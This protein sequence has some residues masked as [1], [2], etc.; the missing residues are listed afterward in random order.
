L[1]DYSAEA[2]DR[3]LEVIP[4]AMRGLAAELRKSGQNLEPSHFRL[5]ACLH[6]EQ[7]SLGELAHQSDVSAA[8]MSRTVS[9]LEE[10][11]WVHR[12]TSPSD[13]RVVLVELT[14]EGDAILQAIT[15]KA[16]EWTLN[17]LRQLSSEEQQ[18]LLD[19]LE[20]LHSMMDGVSQDA[21]IDR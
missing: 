19:G 21:I 17:R 13:G 7:L 8:T 5:L 15:Q 2:A 4:R 1:Q 20:V 6:H 14:E 9:T 18:R 11:G 10:R 12:A 16:R 3:L